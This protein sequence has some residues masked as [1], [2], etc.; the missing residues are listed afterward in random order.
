MKGKIRSRFILRLDDEAYQRTRFSLRIRPLYMWLFVTLFIAVLLVLAGSFIIM[1]PLNRLLPDYLPESQRIASQQAI[2]RLDSM[3][4]VLAANEAW[5]RNF[6]RVTDIDRQPADSAAY[7]RD[8]EEYNPDSIP[9]A[10]PLERQFVNAMEERERFN[11]SVLA[12]LDADGMLFVPV[13]AQAYFDANARKASD[14]TILLPTDSPLQ[15]IADGSVLAVFY[16]T[17]ARGYT[18]LL[19]HARGFVSAYAHVGSPLIVTGDAVSAGQPIA[20]APA[21]DN[22]AARWIQLR[23]WHN[24]TALI[25]YK[26]TGNE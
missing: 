25:P 19:Q 18:I 5:L 24:G 8:P 21:P 22:R 17:Q 12:P 11:I 26:I 3:S 13:A 6:R 1:S 7:A 9:D 15:A 23:I 20:L 4:N 14:P 16:N 2:M 10:S